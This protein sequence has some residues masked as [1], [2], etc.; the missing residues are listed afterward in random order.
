MAADVPCVTEREIM[1]GI[2]PVAVRRPRKRCRPLMS[3][4]SC[5]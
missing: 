2:G 5:R 4:T 1:T 3:L